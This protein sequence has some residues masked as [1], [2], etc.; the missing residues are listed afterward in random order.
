MKEGSKGTCGYYRREKVRRG[1]ITLVMFLIPLIIFFSGYLYYHTRSNAL[2]IV[3]VLGMLPASRAAVSWI[4]VMLQKDAPP[5]AVRIAMKAQPPLARG[6]EL[7]VTA[8]EG[9]MPLDAVVI[10]GS[11]VAAYSSRAPKDKISFMEKHIAKMLAGSGL[12]GRN[13][14]IF[15]EEKR[16]ETRVT[17]L[18][19]NPFQYTDLQEAEALQEQ[20]EKALR[21]L[22]A[23]SI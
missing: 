20:N 23:I 19:D 9:R 18:S 11:E 6:F 1:L 8:Y 2:S 7:T 15:T 4:M 3:A 14:K 17:T 12:T 16:F 5:S 21:T 22:M 13:V 10:C